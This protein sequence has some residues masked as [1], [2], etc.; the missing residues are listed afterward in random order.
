MN[1]FICFCIFFLYCGPTMTISSGFKLNQEKILWPEDIPKLVFVEIFSGHVPLN[2]QA[3]EM[4]KNRI[5]ELGFKVTE[6]YENAEGI[7]QGNI[8]GEASTIWID[9]HISIRLINVKNNLTLW[10]VEA[11]D[12]RLFSW[13][14]S[15]NESMRYAIKEGIKALKKDLIAQMK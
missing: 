6:I 13:T 11:H 12:P 3:T 8:V 1:K 14:A 5:S 9:A 10:S 7:F 15:I 4:W 2:Q